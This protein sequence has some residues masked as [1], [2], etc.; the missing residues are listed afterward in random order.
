QYA[1]YGGPEVLAVTAA[2]EPHP[3]PGQVRIRVR[4][5]SV[6]P[7]D[8]KLRSGMMAQG[9]ELDAPAGLGFDASGVVDEVGE[10]VTGVAPGD[11]VFGLGTATAA[12]LALL[13]SWT[14]KPA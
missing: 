12:E 1:R 7:L 3:G 9:A 8:W 13:D 10:G 14:A 6:N 4:A 2:P 11:E 5:S